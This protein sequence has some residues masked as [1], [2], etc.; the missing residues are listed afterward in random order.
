MKKRWLLPLM[1]LVLVSAGLAAAIWPSSPKQHPDTA[2]YIDRQPGLVLTAGLSSYSGLEKTAAYLES[3]QHTVTRQRL[4]RPPDRRY[5]QRVLDTLTVKTYPF[6]GTQ[7]RLRLEFFNDRLYEI[8]FTPDDPAACLAALK[9]VDPGLHRDR[10]GRAERVQG[11]LRVATNVELAST[12]VG[13]SLGTEPYVLWQDLRLV[14]E[15]DDWDTR[16]GALPY[17]LE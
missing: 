9:R 13:E 10:N 8:S 16:F 14:H 7:G 5:P 4:A 2:R 15:R 17:S 11:S 12:P 6:L 3:R 1:I